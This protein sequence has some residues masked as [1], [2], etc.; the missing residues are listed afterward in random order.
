MGCDVLGSE[1]GGCP[2]LH[3][4]ATWSQEPVPGRGRDTWGLGPQVAGSPCPE[5]LDWA[6]WATGCREDQGRALGALTRQ[7][8]SGSGDPRDESV[9]PRVSKAISAILCR[10]DTCDLLPVRDRGGRGWSGS[11]TRLQG[12]GSLV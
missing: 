2:A 9:K 11:G 8:A 3:G 6:G 4:P 1:A 12:G 10:T 5:T 7:R